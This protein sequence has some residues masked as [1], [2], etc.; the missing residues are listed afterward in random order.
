ML[1]WRRG[2]RPRGLAGLSGGGQDR[3]TPGRRLGQRVQAGFV[4]AQLDL[5]DYQLAAQA[6]RRNGAADEPRVWRQQTSIQAQGPELHQRRRAGASRGCTEVPPKPSWTRHKPRPVAQG[7]QAAYTNLVADVA[8]RGHGCR[9]RAG[10]V[11]TA[12]TPGGAYCADGPRDVVFAVPEDKV[13]PVKVG[14]AVQIKPLGAGAV[15]RRGA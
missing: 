11:V 6:P 15:D 8:G 12:G 9:C 2:S 14:S 10:Q 13:A 4:L 5:Q 1:S 7:N 3:P